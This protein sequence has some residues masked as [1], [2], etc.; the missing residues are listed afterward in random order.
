M[1][2]RNIVKENGK[3]NG[4]KTGFSSLNGIDR[5]KRIPR[6]NRSD[7]H[8]VL[9]KSKFLIPARKTLLKKGTSITFLEY[10]LIDW[11]LSYWLCRVFYFCLSRLSWRFHGWPNCF[12]FVTNLGQNFI[13]IC[14]LGH[15]TSFC[16]FL[17]VMG[18]HECAV[19]SGALPALQWRACASPRL[20]PAT[21]ASKGTPDTSKTGGVLCELGPTKR[22]FVNRN[23]L[24]SCTSE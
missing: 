19:V 24:D 23:V 2:C 22:D 18:N 11:V 7:H 1:S 16:I 8:L 6:W 15:K 13:Y 14:I 5:S 21:F 20:D 9:N 12:L 4:E 10:Y 3:E 17:L